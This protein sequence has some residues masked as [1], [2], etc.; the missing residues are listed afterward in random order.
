MNVDNWLQREVLYEIAM[1]IGGDLNE[2]RMLGKCLPMFLRRL[3]A[4]AVCVLE[5]RA[6]GEN[7]HYRPVHMLPRKADYSP[8]IP[9]LPEAGEESALPIPLLS[10]PDR[11]HYA[12][13]L[14]GF[15]AL[16][17]THR[18][19]PDDLVRET[20]Q[21]AHKL[22]SALLAC[23][24]HAR[25]EASLLALEA[26]RNEAEHA[27]RA[28][29]EMSHALS[30]SHSLLQSVI[31]H[32][33]MRVYWKD[34]DLNY[35]G[36][37][38]AFARD[39][40]KDSP[41]DMIGKDDYQMA[42]ASQADLYRAD[43][44]RVMTI[45]E[46]RLRYE[47]PLTTPDGHKIWLRASKAPLY[48]P[49]GEVMGVLGVYE[50]ITE[51]KRIQDALRASEERFDLA[52]HAANDG[53]WD[54]NLQTHQ[55]YFSP[56][57]KS[58]LGYADNEL[59]NAFSTWEQLV[60]E[61]SRT[62]T[63]AAIEDCIAGRAAGFA[64]EFRMRHKDGHWVDILSRATLIR[65]EAGQP[66]RM[67]G[68]HV[69]I[70]E[71]KRSETALRKSEHD[72]KE[73]QRLAKVGSWE[74]DIPNNRLTWSDEIYRIF[75]IDPAQFAASYEAFLYAIHP[76]D[77]EAVNAAYANSLKNR[78][79]YSIH[80]RLRMAD[81]RVKHVH[82]QCQTDFDATGRPLRS[83]GTVQD[84]TEQVQSELALRNS[85]SLL[86]AVIDHVPMRVFW[87][88]MD[89][90]YLGCNP[91]FA[92]DAGKG[93]P[94][95]MI[96]K[97]D[98]QMGWAHEAD[99][100]RADD[101]T[102]IGSG[103]PRIN[104]EEPQTTPDGRTLWLRTSKVPMKN[105][106][107][108]VIGV[109]GIYE[110]ITEAKQLQEELLRHR[111]HLEELVE[112]RTRDLKIARQQAESANV[113]KSSFLANMSHELRTPMNAIIGMTDLALATDP[114]DR[115]RNYLEKLKTASNTL[116]HI[117]NDILDFSKIE[118]GRLEME[119][120]PFVLA[121]VFDQISGV[122]ALRAENQ[123]IELTY[124]IDD[125]TRLLI[126][127]PLRLGQVL[128]NLVTNALKFST[129]GN[130]IVRV[131]TLSA[132][133]TEAELHFAVSDEGIGI[134]PE[135]VANLFRP[136]TQADTSTT[137]KYGGTGLGLAICRHLV[138][139][140]HGRIWV[141]SEVGKG[142]T[143]HFTVKL[144][145]T[146]Q[147]RRR[148]LAQS[149]AGLAGLAGR[150]LLLVDDNPVDLRILGH[151]IERLGLRVETARS[152][153]EALERVK[154]DTVPDYL[155]CLIDWRMPEVDGIEAIRQLHAAFAARGLEPPPMLLVTAYSHQSDLK[156]VSH[157]IDG[158]LAKPVTARRLHDELARCLGALKAAAPAI[159]RRKGA[160]AQWARFR[161]LDILL[162]EDIEINQE[163]I[164][165]L[166][167]NL[168][169]SAR[170][171]GNGS[172][173]LQAVA[174]RK[175][176]LILMDCQMPIMDGY[177]A[178]RRLRAQP[179]YQ[180]LPIIA[181]TANATVADQ[182]KCFEAGMNA[183]VAKP[184]SMDTL[185]ERMAQCLPDVETPATT[186]PPPTASPAEPGKAAS[187]LPDF[188]G[189]DMAVGLAH[190]DGMHTLLLRVLLSFRDNLGKNFEA[191]FA[192]AQTNGDW[193]TQ[194][195]LAHSLKGVARTLGATTLGE[196]ALA[197]QV[198]AEEQDAA[199][200]ASLLPVVSDQLH[201]VIEGL[202]DVDKYLEAMK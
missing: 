119:S 12:W 128:I 43:D 38:P 134:S 33:P 18:H 21:L 201:V 173:V 142:S 15:G 57:W 32:V 77:R 112:E 182:Q 153:A 148:G 68:T 120:T 103:I 107:D 1:A 121:D 48:N 149:A 19:L 79:P 85:R 3:G 49:Q 202:A 137:R 84:V 180:A 81:G 26:S 108:E 42:W 71:R 90:N 86:Q 196:S 143:F 74:L 60:D 179:E 89:L 154:A 40:G 163:V 165:E 155:A 156:S 122:V 64:V 113:A 59:E 22:A 105:P 185:Y 75:E 161:H 56:R 94:A 186:F 87:K 31:D 28:L 181:L 13:R 139:A 54:W 169:L 177:E 157:E 72:L 130:V 200:C 9:H 124:D 69:D 27:N 146:G 183:H 98:Y 92:R 55:V 50:D 133:E 175:P 138:E 192:A 126:G 129:G 198:A 164:L 190:V 176:D 195:R 162:A 118:A 30:R 147:D 88:D 193:K 82:E 5:A 36:C 35:L 101:R 141:D 174:D 29:S 167:A 160:T 131:E 125:D 7:P 73:A 4:T 45:G 16:I 46:A 184:I 178:T 194:Y 171:A 166:L 152:A 104:F 197:L 76:D 199:R 83:V 93:S 99:L 39:A 109:L 145:V 53:L 78:E 96:G 123:G 61:E 189:I 144:G 106:D 70:S 67:V 14:P 151:L 168:G 117:I 140:M 51:Q 10:A 132:G 52:L 25:L 150:P 58:M 116:L 65:D 188:P 115:Q 63:M 8:V 20:E 66:L 97:D 80:H 34:R 114:T 100:Y 135:Q 47:E 127:D 24:Q 11:S 17:L 102:V 37:N 136:F 187:A 110:D 6:P 2:E 44:L 41:T 62:T 23:R 111:D 159:D 91:A 170:L 158:L 95:D 191:D 172:E